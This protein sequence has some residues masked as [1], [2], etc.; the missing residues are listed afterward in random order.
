PRHPGT[1]VAMNNLAWTLR[2]RG[3]LEEAEKIQQQVL[4]LQTEV[5]GP[6]HP[7]TIVAMNNLALTLRDRGQLE[8]AEKMK[9]QVLEL[10]TEVLGPRHPDTIV[11]MNNLALTLRDRGQLEEAEKIQRQVLELQTEVLGPRHPSTIVAMNNLALTLRDRGQLEEAEKMKRQVLE[12]RTEVLGPRHPDTIVSMNNLAWTLGDRGQLE[13][14]EKI[15]RQALELLTEILGSQHP[16]TVIAMRNY[17]QIL[18]ECVKLKEAEKLEQDAVIVQSNS[19]HVMILVLMAFHK[20]SLFIDQSQVPSLSNMNMVRSGEQS[21]SSFH[22]HHKS[23]ADQ[24]LGFWWFR[25]RSMT[26]WRGI[27]I[28]VSPGPF[29]LFFNITQKLPQCRVVER[30]DIVVESTLAIPP[31]ETTQVSV[32]WSSIMDDLRNWVLRLKDMIYMSIGACSSPSFSFAKPLVLGLQGAFARRYTPNATSSRVVILQD[33]KEPLSV[34][35]EGKTSSGMVEL[36]VPGCG[37]RTTRV[38]LMVLLCIPKLGKVRKHARDG[39]LKNT[40][41]LDSA[42]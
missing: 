19:G 28:D 16:H 33:S 10:Q 39:V 6:R 25:P 29:I 14:A 5:L 11:A 23:A 12:L 13:E 35:A 40:A 27:A 32:V 20:C 34:A 36:D 1:I 8:E 17:D 2:D 22:Q 4:E 42:L 18:R 26:Y 7:G 24:M 9:R 3:Q 21:G 38:V 41:W 37:T 31:K 15:Q 30:E